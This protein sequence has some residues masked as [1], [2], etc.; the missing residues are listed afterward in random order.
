[1]VT[2]TGNHLESGVLQQ[3][4]GHLGDPYRYFG[5]IGTP[6]KVYGVGY[7]PKLLLVGLMDHLDQDVSHDTTRRP[8]VD[9]SPTPL[10]TLHSLVGEGPDVVQPAGEAICRRGTRHRP[11]TQEWDTGQHQ[12]ADHLGTFRSKTHRYPATKRVSDQDWGPIEGIEDSCHD[13]GIS[14]CADHL[15]GRGRGTKA[16]EVRG[17]R[18]KPFE[19]CCKVDP[20]SSPAMKCEDAWWARAVHLGEERAVKK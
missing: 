19:S 11:Q 13:V 20:T 17:E 9:R 6:E 12:T 4:Q 15:V 5:V 1:M 3:L 7:P 16:R 10:Q 8:I 2:H 18:R 14:V